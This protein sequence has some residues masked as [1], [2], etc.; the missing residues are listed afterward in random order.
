MGGMDLHHCRRRAGRIGHCSSERPLRSPRV[1]KKSDT[2]LKIRS[3]GPCTYDEAVVEEVDAELA[4]RLLG[5]RSGDGPGNG[6]GGQG[7]CE[8]GEENGA[9]HNEEGEVLR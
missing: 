7:G 4:V 5:K 6:N 9:L 3:C 8:G 2:G 1:P